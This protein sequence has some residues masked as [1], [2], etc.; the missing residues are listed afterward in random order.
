MPS[1]V[2]SLLRQNLSGAYNP[3]GLGLNR[4]AQLGPSPVRQLPAPDPTQVGFFPSGGSFGADS[5]LSAI[6]PL[7]QLI[8]PF[9][10]GN[11]SI[12]PFSGA[13]GPGSTSGNPL[14]L[15]TAIVQSLRPSGASA[16]QAAPTANPMSSAGS[17]GAPTGGAASAAS[18]MQAVLRMLGMGG[19]G[20]DRA[21]LGGPS[22][23][24]SQP[25]SGP[26]EGG[27][28]SGGGPGI[29]VGENVGGYGGTI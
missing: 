17:A 19:G 13:T 27:T 12:T 16:P 20:G 23:G 9:V 1:I 11:V 22:A 3:V 10:Q 28:A 24:G 7:L 18:P 25:G 14:D 2:E 21:G 26:F 29:G 4:P 15:L 8:A 5:D 6:L